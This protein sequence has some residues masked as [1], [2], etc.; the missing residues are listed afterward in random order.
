MSVLGSW[1]NK[2]LSSR[3]LK[4]LDV[5]YEIWLFFSWPRFFFLLNCKELR[6]ICQKVLSAQVGKDLRISSEK[7]G[8][9]F[10]FQ[11]P[12]PMCA[13]PARVYENITHAR[14]ENEIPRFWIIVQP[15]P[16]AFPH[17]NHISLAGEIIPPFVV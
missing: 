13:I 17:E 16:A 11:P 1:K 15:P 3:F 7:R 6:N 2:I 9:I 4:N 12:N 5:V 8:T 10:Q 14:V